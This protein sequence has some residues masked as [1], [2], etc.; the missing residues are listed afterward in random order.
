MYVNIYEPSDGNV[1]NNYLLNQG[2]KNDR[3]KERTEKKG[4]YFNATGLGL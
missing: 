4:G 1:N 2:K 3:D